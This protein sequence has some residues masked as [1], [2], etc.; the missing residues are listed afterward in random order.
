MGAVP[1]WAY[2]GESA[3]VQLR[4]K[5]SALA[6]STNAI[7]G[8]F[9]NIVLPYELAAIGPTTG[10]MFFGFGV[11]T[12]LAVWFLI[13]ELSGRTYA[14]MD[15]LFEKKIPARKFKSTICTGDYGNQHEAGH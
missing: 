10:Y 3:S 1:G 15:E 4:A 8:G 7:I 14:E 9:W 12:T 6:S 5:T 11:L 13:P 2:L